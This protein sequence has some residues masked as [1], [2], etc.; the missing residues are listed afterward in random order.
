MRGRLA[1]LLPRALASAREKKRWKKSGANVLA[2]LGLRFLRLFLE[3]THVASALDLSNLQLLLRQYVYS[4]TSKASKVSTSSSRLRVF[5][6]GGRC[7]LTRPLSLSGIDIRS[8]SLFPYVSIRQHTSAYVIRQHT[9]YV[10]LLDYLA[11]LQ[12]TSYVSI[13]ALARLLG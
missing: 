6:L 10:R 8:S 13:R 7:R 1:Y 5:A 4:C 11:R 12:H 2:R 3:D 9:S